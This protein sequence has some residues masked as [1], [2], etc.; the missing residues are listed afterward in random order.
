MLFTLLMEKLTQ[1]I[2]SKDLGIKIGDERLSML[3]FADDVVL[4]AENRE[5]LQELLYE[6]SEFSK[7][8]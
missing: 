4:L 6:A 7:N 1:R 5:D 3:L 8:M 2:K